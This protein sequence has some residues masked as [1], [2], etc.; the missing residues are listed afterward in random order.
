MSQDK[1]TQM[2]VVDR[3][4]NIRILGLCIWLEP[5]LKQEM[6]DWPSLTVFSRELVTNRMKALEMSGLIKM[7]TNYCLPKNKVVCSQ[8]ADRIIREVLVEARL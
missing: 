3:F 7:T 5:T 4:I 6:Y 1:L 2:A 8:A